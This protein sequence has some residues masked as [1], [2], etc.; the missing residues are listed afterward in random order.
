MWVHVLWWLHCCL[1]IIVTPK[2]T[3]VVA[4]LAVRYTVAVRFNEDIKL[5]SRRFRDLA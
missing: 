1:I 3:M 4:K 2:L 5:A